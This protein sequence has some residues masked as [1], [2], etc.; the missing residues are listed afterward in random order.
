M[1]YE[2]M[3]LDEL[4]EKSEA[5]HS[6]IDIL[7]AEEAERLEKAIRVFF[8]GG[9][10]EYTLTGREQYA[11]PSI[12]CW[13][14]R[15]I[16]KEKAIQKGAGHWN[17]KG[18]ITPENQKERNSKEYTAWRS[19]VF[20][21]DNFTCQICGQ[22]GGRLNAHHIQPWARCIQKRFDVNNGITL[23]E[24]CHR[25]IHKRMRGATDD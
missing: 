25:D 10:I 14:K 17:W 3:T 8:G 22:V 24:K 11:Y 19:Q 15:F 4:F 12:C 1:K 18:G 2:K 9:D 23:C 20:I 6:T 13:F 16:K 5:W 21:R 7:T